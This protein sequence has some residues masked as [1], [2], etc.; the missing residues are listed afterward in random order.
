MMATSLF[1]RNYAAA[2]RR[3]P[4]SASKKKSGDNNDRR[5]HQQLTKGVPQQKTTTLEVGET[6]V[7]TW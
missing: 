6:R 4:P 5:I 2:G 7:S 3:G 1:V